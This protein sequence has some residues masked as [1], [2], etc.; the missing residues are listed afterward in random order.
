[1][2]RDETLNKGKGSGSGES[3]GAECRDEEEHEVQEQ[4]FSRAFPQ[5]VD[6]RGQRT[7]SQ[8]LRN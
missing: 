3:R 1:M 7:R 6:V 8:A 2:I 4:P 5:D